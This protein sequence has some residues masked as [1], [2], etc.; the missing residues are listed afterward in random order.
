MKSYKYIRKLQYH[1]EPDYNKLKYFVL[2]D[3]ENQG[4]MMNGTYDWTKST[5]SFSQTPSIISQI[6]NEIILKS[7]Y[8]KEFQKISVENASM[9]ADYKDFMSIEMEENVSVSL[10]ELSPKRN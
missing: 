6:S 2:K 8:E 10:K 1:E 9:E 3:L 4:L 5:L 7:L